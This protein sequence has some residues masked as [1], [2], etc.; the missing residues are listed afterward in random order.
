MAEFPQFKS[1]N[2]YVAE[3]YTTFSPKL[4]IKLLNI[5]LNINLKIGFR[6]RGVQEAL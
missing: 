1:T 6:K 4:C 2:A 5:C 3:E